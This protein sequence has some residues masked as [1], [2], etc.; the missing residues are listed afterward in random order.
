MSSSPNAVRKMLRPMRPNP[1]MPTL[2]AIPDSNL[3]CQC[4][5]GCQPVL[6]DRSSLLACNS[7]TSTG[8]TQCT[9]LSTADSSGEKKLQDNAR[10][11]AVS[12]G[13]FAKLFETAYSVLT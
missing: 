9:S 10:S 11:A 7:H 3:L 12:S 5:T 13:H 1:L 4:R 8:V 6:H 2:T